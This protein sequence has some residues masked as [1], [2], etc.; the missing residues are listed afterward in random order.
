MSAPWT[1]SLCAPSANCSDKTRRNNFKLKYGG[2]GLAIRKKFF[3]MNVVRDLKKL[4][5][6][7]VKI[8]SMEAFKARLVEAS[9]DAHGRGSRTEGSL[10]SL[11]TKNILQFYSSMQ[12]ISEAFVPSLHRQVHLPLHST[13]LSSTT[14]SVL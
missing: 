12:T 8:P 2:F 6:E 4:P 5:R 9:E 7:V 10:R 11:P 13:F 14:W 3:S 1:V